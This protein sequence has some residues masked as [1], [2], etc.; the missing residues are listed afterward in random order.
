[1]EDKN[2]KLVDC[3]EEDGRE[4]EIYEYKGVTI[5]FNLYYENEFTIDDYWY[6]SLEKAKETIDKR[7]E[8]ENERKNEPEMDKWIENKTHRYGKKFYKGFEISYNYYKE[9]E[10]IVRFGEEEWWYS[11]LEKAMI[12]IDK[13]NASKEKNND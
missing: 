7:I 6:T 9:K 1:M 3:Y 11:T 2:L 12:D 4:V 8:I 13:C 5:C 10:F